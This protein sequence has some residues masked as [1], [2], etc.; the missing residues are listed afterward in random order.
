MKISF[1]VLKSFLPELKTKNQVVDLLSMYAFEAEDAGGSLI[2]IKLPPNR[3]SDAGSYIGIAK[4]LAA[5]LNSKK[6]KDIKLLSTKTTKKPKQFNVRIENKNFCPR[7]CA[8]YF[9]GIVIKESPKWLKDALISSGMRPINN[10]VD[11]MNYVMME[12]GQPLHAF[13]YDLLSPKNKPEII[14]R[15]AQKGEELVSLDNI[16]YVLDPSIGLITDKEKPLVIAGIKGGI[17]CEVTEVTKRII[18]EA[19]NFDPVAI[20]KTTKKINLSTDAS[21]RF[22]HALSIELPMYALSR[23]AYILKE[24]THAKPGD[25]FD[26]LVKSANEKILAFD[27]S[28]CNE[29]LGTKLSEKQATSCLSRLGFVNVRKNLWRAPLLRV[30]IETPEDLAEEVARIIGYE[31]IPSCAPRA[32]II[33]PEENVGVI[34]KEKMRGM[35]RNFGCNEVYTHSFVSREHLELGFVFSGEVIPLLNPPSAEFAFLRPSLLPTLSLRVEDNFRFY[36]EVRM[37]EIGDV[38]LKSN[39]E[40][41]S[42]SLHV[43]ISIAKKSGETFFELKGMVDYILKGVGVSEYTLIETNSKSQKFFFESALRIESGKQI[44]GF[45]GFNSSNISF[46]ELNLSA[47]LRVQKEDYGYRGIEKFPSVTRDIS[48]FTDLDVRIGDVIEE[49]ILSDN[50]VRDVDLLDEYIDETWANLQ[51]ITLRVVFQADDRTLTGEEVDRIL[52][53]SI[54]IL[55][56]KFGIKM[57]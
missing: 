9:D 34:I 5:I 8:Q 7:Y 21:Q 35:L 43:G 36:D 20:Y 23:V 56:K 24:I 27:V 26:S 11:A 40:E 2:E 41:Y 6:L 25:R 22:V 54:Q 17:G 44:L 48:M 14:I 32:L 3:Y 16:R 31:N 33:A 1:P 55:Q 4:E 15:N 50:L 42:E 18:V 37:F 51:S 38:F 45:V 10:V 53:H 57:R 39:K 19:A 13:D 30:D 47:I 52:Q 28:V 49:I 46:A 12:T 29:L